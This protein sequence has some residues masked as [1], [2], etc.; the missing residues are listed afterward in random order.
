MISQPGVTV[1]IKLLE[2]YLGIL[3]FNRTN[4]RVSLTDAGKVF[5][6]EAIVLVKEF[7]GSIDRLHAYSEGY[8]RKWS[9]AISPLMAETILPYILRS[10]MEKHSDLE[11]SIRVEESAFIEELVASGE[12]NIGISALNATRKDIEAIELY[13][14]PLLF[15]V[16]TDG[17]EEES[18]P[19]FDTEQYLKQNYLFTHHHPVV[20]DGLLLQLRKQ[21]N[22]IRT[23]RVT[24]AHI[25][26]RFIQEGL[27][28]SFLPQSIIKRE[29]IEGRVM[30]IPFDL[31][32]LP[33]VKT[34][35][36]LK[37]TGELEQEFIE[38]ISNYYF[39]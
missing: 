14:D 17:Y 4:K 39:G 37:N 19:I 15:I 25:V 26:K 5:Y 16:P 18:A 3:L 8:R 38:K 2:E 27:G 28:A 13:E 6:L 20:W 32:P 29:L 11:V 24:Q 33:K 22:T 23:M 35:L 36:L 9:V 1:H 31:F 7:E 21:V 12:V 34:F 30:N 10:F